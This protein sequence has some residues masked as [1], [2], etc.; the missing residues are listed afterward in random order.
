[1]RIQPADSVQSI[2][3]LAAS[4]GRIEEMPNGLLDQLVAVPTLAGIEFL[5]DLFCQI[6]A[7]SVTSMAVSSPHHA[8]EAR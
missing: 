5:L 2:E 7:G 3:P 4:L 8:F 1:M 6:R